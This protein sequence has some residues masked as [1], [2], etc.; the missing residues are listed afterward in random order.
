MV[1]QYG[2]IAAEIMNNQWKKDYY[3]FLLDFMT[4]NPATVNPETVNPA[5]SHPDDS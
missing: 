4:L 3:Q 2:K 1:Q 5:T